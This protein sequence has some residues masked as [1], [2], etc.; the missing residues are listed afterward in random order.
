MNR[1]QPAG[2]QQSIR[3]AERAAGMPIVIK[4]VRVPDTAF[5]GRVTKKAGFLLLEYQVAQPGYFWH[6][7]IIEELLR[8]IQAGES[9]A[10]IRE[11]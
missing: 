2:L 9:D 11:P 6:I 4:E 5:R 7:P 1:S 10:E 8:R 3:Q